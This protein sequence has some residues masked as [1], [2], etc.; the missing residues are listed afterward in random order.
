MISD[1]D[2]LERSRRRASTSATS[3]SSLIRSKSAIKGRPNK[4]SHFRALFTLSSAIVKKVKSVGKGPKL[5]TTFLET[6]S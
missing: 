6:I 3:Q 5:A 4:Y 2:E 1:K